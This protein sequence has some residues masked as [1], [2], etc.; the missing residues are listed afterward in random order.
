[1][2]LAIPIIA[3]GSLYIASNNEN[4][5]CRKIKEGYSNLNSP[6]TLPNTNTPPQNYPVINERELVD[7]TTNYAN[8]NSATDKYFN[9][10]VYENN[11][12]K[13]MNVGNQIQS[14]YSLTGDYKAPSDFKHNNMIPFYS[15][16]KLKGKIFNE[17][18]AESFMDNMTGG[19]SQLIKKIEQAPLF[20]PEDNVQWAHGAPNSSDFYQSRVNPGMKSSNVKPFESEIVG[21]GLDKGYTTQGSDG[22]NAGM[23]ARDKWQDKTVDELRIKTNPKLEFTLDN[24]EGPSYAHIQNV[25]ILGKMEKYR[26]DTFFIQNQDRWLTTNGQ[27]KGQMLR[28]IEEVHQPSRTTTTCSYIGPATSGLTPLTYAPQTFEKTKRIEPPQIDVGPSR[29]CNRGDYKDKDIFLKSHTNYENNRSTNSQ[30]DSFRSGFSLAIGAVISPLMDIFNPTRR[31]EYVNNNRIYGTMMNSVPK[32]YVYN[33]AD[34][35][36]TTIKETTLYSPNLFVGSQIKGT[37]Y[38][39]NP[40]QSIGNARDS[41]TCGYIGSGGNSASLGWGGLNLESQCNQRINLDKEPTLNSRTEMGNTQIFNQQMNVNVARYDCDRD[42]NR[43][44]VP[45]SM[46]STNISNSQYGQIRKPLYNND[47]MQTERINP[48]IISQLK[49]NPYAVYI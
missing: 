16:N 34:T 35:T 40:Q 37:G 31:E 21:P 41:T 6:N 5:K 3:L 2:E 47:S 30:P 27:E 24:L 26:P 18:I 14:I 36:K 45:T 46:P 44:W 38:E 15:G 1:M 33:P 4:K 28:P 48:D 25:G 9:Q 32:D 11:T 29:A 22:F 23:E 49:S 43:M 12:R 7:T 13:N 17:D 42:N 39:T 19:G 10:N 8:S 20:K